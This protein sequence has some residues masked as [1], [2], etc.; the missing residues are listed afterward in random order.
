[1]G[2]SRNSL[3]ACCRGRYFKGMAVVPRKRKNQVVYYVSNAVNGS[4]KWERVGTDK[5]EAERRDGAMKREIAAGTYCGRPT[6]ASTV[7]S[8]ARDWLAA[9]T[10][11]SAEDERSW[12]HNHVTTRCRWFVDLKL[13]DVRVLHTV[14]LAKEL[15][16]PYEVVGGSTRKLS[17]KSVFNIFGVISTM[18]RDARIAELM[19]RNVCEMPRGTLNS[20]PTVRRQPYSTATVLTLATDDRLQADWRMFLILLFYTGMR[21]GE[22]CGRRFRDWDRNTEPLGALTVATQYNDQ[23]LKTEDKVGEAPRVIPVHPHLER[24]LDLWWREGFEHVYC[25]RPTK[26]DFIVPCRARKLGNH[27]RSSA[28]KLFRRALAA[29]GV[30][31]QSLHAT[32]HTFITLARRDGA[33]KDVLE[34]VT[35]NARGEMIDAYTHFDWDPLCEAVACFMSS[36]PK[37]PR[38]DHLRVVV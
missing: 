9:R 34:R 32:R 33:R 28:Y 3:R 38:R 35:H 18:F 14:R 12:W 2:T 20:K 5:R 16:L 7:G 4:A 23:P 19:V 29:V 1:M 10:N 13:E 6:G 37:P 36:K 17:S 22:A 15:A 25:R 24:A 27:T 8:Y 26:D 31:T 11:R 21:E 30:E